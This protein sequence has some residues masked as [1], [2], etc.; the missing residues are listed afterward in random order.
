M[1][2]Q[3]IDETVNIME[4]LRNNVP[5]AALEQKRMDALNSFV[6]N[7]DTPEQ[8]VN[9][10]ARYYLRNE[11]LDTLERIQ[12]FFFE[13]KLADLKGLASTYLL[14]KK[15]QIFIVGDKTISIK[16]ENE[17]EITLEEHLS[18]LA[19]KI[20]IPFTEIKLR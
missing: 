10:Y 20:G 8:L 11:P 16:L 12:D 1:T 14:P 15:L 17:K 2:A 7:V 6:F 13:T 19:E 4:A 9:A 3:A 18:S 5:P